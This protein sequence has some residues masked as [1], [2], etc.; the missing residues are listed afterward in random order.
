MKKLFSFFAAVLFAGSMMA[1]EESVD[2]S[3]QGYSNQQAIASYE[4]TTFSVAFSKGTNNNAPKYYDAGTA[5]RC[6]GGNTFTVTSNGTDD[7]LSIK[8]TIADGGNANEITTDLGT[9]SMTD[10]TW[11]GAAKSVTFTIGGTSGN[12]R[13]GGL[14]VET[15]ISLEPAISAKNIDFGDI[16]ISKEKDAFVLDTT[17][18][19][20]GANLTN[21]ISATG[22]EHVT[23]SG[24]LTTEGGTLNLHIVAAP[25]EFSEV[26]TLSSGET[27]K[28]VTISGSVTAIDVLPGIPA[29][30]EAGENALEA[31]V[32]SI[33]GVKGGTGSKGGSL[34]ITVPANTTKLH[35]FAAAWNNEG[36]DLAIEAPEGVTLSKTSV[37]IL[38]DAGIAGSGTNYKLQT[39][40]PADDCRFDIDLSGVTA[41]T[42]ITISRN[43]G[44]K[45]FAVW[46]A[47][48][49]L[50]GETT[51]I[52]NTAVEA[53]AVK[54]LENGILVIEK[55]G[56]KYNVMGQIIK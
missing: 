35:F 56:K 38:A 1:T 39:L 23:L 16:F 4:G 31:T 26:I 43:G 6:Y 12:R 3:A 27:S 24:E 2:F 55:A 10:S 32:N 42:E 18:E 22:S 46:G 47:T 51:A 7:L 5:I 29:T 8:V 14:T 50:S 28:Q 44:N 40:E 54:S 52:S 17:L 13:I 15:G 36:G 33:A 53:K 30:M 37:T 34:T 25:G 49:E 11:T 48:Y 45:R 9:F 19:V 20:L 41:E 21:A